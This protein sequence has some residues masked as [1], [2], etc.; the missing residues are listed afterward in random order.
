VDR[1]LEIVSSFPPVRGMVLAAALVAGACSSAPQTFGGEDTP[2][3]SDIRSLR[4]VAEG[5]DKVI[6]LTTLPA[7]CETQPASPEQAAQ[8]YLGKIAFESP[9]LL[10]GTAARMELSCA[11][12]HRN[13]RGNPDFFLK[14]LSDKPGTADVTSSVMSRVRGDGNFNPVVIPDIAMR[15]GKQIKD[16][17]GAEFRTKVHGLVVEEFDGQEP[18]PYVFDALG[19]Y[20]DGLDPSACVSGAP[21]ERASLTR[22]FSA[23]EAAYNA[24]SDPSLD[25]ASKLFYLR[26]SRFALGRIYERFV[27]PELAAQRRELLTFSNGIGQMAEA[28]RIGRAAT[29]PEADWVEL[30]ERLGDGAAKSLYN[31]SAIRAAFAGE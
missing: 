11:S 5:T 20:L 31:A 2:N 8:R 1:R 22:D 12:C 6:F 4:W 27:G 16:R 30:L 10:G 26:V 19:A 18:P 14:S 7:A 17:K 25:Q 23:A 13:G 28:A 24:A 29:F 9:A 15:D 3:A 21:S